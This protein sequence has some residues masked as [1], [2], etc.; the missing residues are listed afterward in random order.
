MK[1][2]VSHS[3]RLW[4]QTTRSDNNNQFDI[5]ESYN[6]T[7]IVVFVDKYKYLGTH[8]ANVNIALFG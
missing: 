4:F 7:V 1:Y 6:K 3:V 2:R 8:D 5:A